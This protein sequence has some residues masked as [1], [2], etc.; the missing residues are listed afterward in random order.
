M[1]KFL[2]VA[3][4]G[5]MII[6][7]YAFE[8]L[9]GICPILGGRA[10]GKKAVVT[11]A[12]IAGVMLVTT[13]ICWPIRYFFLAPNSLMYLE[14]VVYVIVALDVTVILDLCVKAAFKESL[15]LYF[16]VIVL[17][18]AVLGAALLGAGCETYLESLFVTLGGG[19]GYMLAMFIF[20]GVSSR[21][22]QK[23]V[24]E[25]FRGLPVNVLA[26]AIVS[27]ALVAFK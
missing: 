13:A 7:N 2:L 6:N 20:A 24:P 19:L 8:N 23:Y 15:G 26:A 16:P 9:L 5:G 21:I 18:G 14:P 27:M 25:A 3:M 22:R 11:G 1:F 17:N 12:F 10:V 4:L